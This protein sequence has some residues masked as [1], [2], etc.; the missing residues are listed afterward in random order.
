MFLLIPDRLVGR[1]G[2]RGQ[3]PGPPSVEFTQMSQVHCALPG[4]PVTPSPAPWFSSPGPCVF[5]TREDERTGW[6]TL[7]A[8][9]RVGTRHQRS[10]CGHVMQNMNPARCLT[11]W[12]GDM[13]LVGGA[14]RTRCR[15]WVSSRSAGTWG[16][17]GCGTSPGPPDS[18]WL[19]SDLLQGAGESKARV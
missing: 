13:R 2:L 9:P 16:G 11:A 8:I 17:Q 14:P 10:P 3:Q 6:S 5:R 4:P 18:S 15:H 19:G 12:K 7:V 1:G